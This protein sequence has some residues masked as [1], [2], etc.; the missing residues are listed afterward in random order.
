MAGGEVTMTG[1]QAKQLFVA[2]GSVE[3]SGITADE[4]AAAA[5]TLR[6]AGATADTVHL[7]GATITLSGGFTGDVDGSGAAVTAVPGTSF[8]GDVTLSGGDIRLA[9]AVSGDTT[10]TAERAELSGQFAGTVVIASQQIAL[11]PGTTIAGTLILPVGSSYAPPEGVTVT[12][13]IERTAPVGGDGVKIVFDRD[14][15]GKPTA[16]A[17]DGGMG[18]SAWFTLLATLGA[19]GALALGVAP[20]FMAAAA[21]K[22][23]TE[24]LPSL[25]VGLASLIA[26]PAALAA[27]AATLIGIP[28][29]VLGAA[30]YA[31]GIGLGVI[32]LC[33]W[34]GLAL[35]ALA[36]QPGDETRLSKLVGWTLMGFLALAA[37]GVVPFAGPALQVLA[38]MAGAGAV[39]STAWAMR[40]PRRPAAGARGAATPA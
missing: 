29:A 32:A 26:V 7:A 17:D 10:I 20:R 37:V 2:G 35:R 12:G 34:G 15:G 39:L 1:A 16:V 6:V 31:I 30:A 38:V 8:A 22:L 5:G 36:R 19:F 13:G 9:G 11:A 40:K 28:F 3:M 18:F 23:A 4:V 21:Q 14:D 27:I 24:P 25:G 33:L